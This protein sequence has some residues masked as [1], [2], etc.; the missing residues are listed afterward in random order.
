[1]ANPT[2][3]SKHP[4]MYSLLPSFALPKTP[5]TE[6]KPETEIHKKS[7]RNLEETKSKKSKK[8]TA[9]QSSP[10]PTKSIPRPA[11]P[12]R[13]PLEK[14]ELERSIPIASSST[15]APP[16]EHK[17]GFADP[18]YELFLVVVEGLKE[19]TLNKLFGFDNTSKEEILTIIKWKCENTTKSLKN[20]SIQLFKNLS[21]VQLSD[22]LYYVSRVEGSRYLKSSV[23]HQQ[24]F[25]IR[26]PS[27]LVTDTR[28]L[29]GE[30]RLNLGVINAAT[31]LSNAEKK[32]INDEF[33]EQAA[34]LEKNIDDGTIRA[35]LKNH[36]DAIR[37]V[38]SD[39]RELIRYI[40]IKT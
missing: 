26:T 25:P 39:L 10:T 20:Q 22:S 5:K 15:S 21:T 35:H 2:G 1:M 31:T 11:S 30:I 8:P 37:E 12:Q 14:P 17:E 13:K 23:R 6:P 7:M 27:Q 9:S 18:G 29:S 24:L 38:E 19:K 36:P 4:N 28:K 34:K 40:R 3:P 16:L 33:L 32:A